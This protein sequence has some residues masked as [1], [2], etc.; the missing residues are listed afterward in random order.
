MLQGR[1]GPV[2]ARRLRAAARPPPGGRIPPSQVEVLHLVPGAV[3]YADD[4][5]PQAQSLETWAES[6]ADGE[7]LSFKRL[8]AYRVAREMVVAV[9]RAGIADPELRSQAHRAG[10]SVLLNLAE[11]LPLTGAARRRH[12]T[13]A[14][15]S[16]HEVVAA[17]DVAAALGVLSEE[18][19]AFIQALCDRIIAMLWRLT[20]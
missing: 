18:D 4:V 2:A 19:S 10:T 16:A 9:G 14:R 5:P 1:N 17:V 20:H 12:L 11:G 3:R 6:T 7:G 13:I 15:A 8:D